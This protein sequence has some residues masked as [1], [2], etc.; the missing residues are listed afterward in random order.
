[1]S[2]ITDPALQ[3][4]LAEREA[5]R[6]E[7]SRKFTEDQ[8]SSMA[9][10][11]MASLLAVNGGGALAALNIAKS[12]QMFWMPGALFGIGIGFAIFSG[13]A[14]QEAQGRYHPY[15]IELERYWATVAYTGQCVPDREVE[16]ENKIKRLSLL[17]R[18]PPIFGWV[19]GCLFAGGMLA[20]GIIVGGDA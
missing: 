4:I 16:I 7:A 19:S 5:A 9:K 13:V 20:L 12:T 18:L 14:M 8:F 11:L 17:M 10:W 15:I 3:K 2:P 1:M 6:M